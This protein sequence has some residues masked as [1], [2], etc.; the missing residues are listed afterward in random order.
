[1]LGGGQRW[2]H[3]CGG[4]VCTCR[5]ELF[6]SPTEQ[7]EGKEKKKQK[8][9]TETVFFICFGRRKRNTFFKVARCHWQL[10]LVGSVRARSKLISTLPKI[11][12]S[13]ILE[14][15]EF[16]ILTV[17]GG[18]YLYVLYVLS[19][20]HGRCENNNNSIASHRCLFSSLFSSLLYLMFFL[21]VWWRSLEL[22]VADRS[23][24]GE[25]VEREGLVLAK[26]GLV[27][28]AFLELHF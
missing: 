19:R 4:F 20:T 1:M 25:R 10:F 23:G 15:R 6:Q 7:A 5:L 28:A 3:L 21:V 16:I 13:D 24:S 11:G 14:S 17:S 8:L 2:L 22:K 9:H 12:W 26:A 18:R 27:A